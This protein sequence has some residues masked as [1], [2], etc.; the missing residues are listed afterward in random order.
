MKIE[1]IS[2]NQIKFY[3]TSG[4]L[5]QRGMQLHELAYGSPKAQGLF[6]E[7][8][9]RAFVE[10]DFH[11]STETP[12]IIEAIPTSPDSIMV[13]VT[14]VASIADMEARFGYPP[15]LGQM[16]NNSAAGMDAS[17]NYAQYIQDLLRQPLQNH[18]HPFAPPVNPAENST[19]AVFIFDNLDQVTAVSSHCAASYIGSNS[20]YKYQGKF[21]LVIDTQNGKLTQHHQNILREYS[22]DFSYLDLSEAYLLEHG[23]TIIPKNAMEIL[24]T[25]LG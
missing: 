14:K 4:D 13:I 23:E 17:K 8:M 2:E 15:I 25:H 21:Y 10:C 16:H 12:L 22:H 24:A 1:R 6:R 7:V 5:T 3:L 20:L 19:V 11:T 18:P 9:Q